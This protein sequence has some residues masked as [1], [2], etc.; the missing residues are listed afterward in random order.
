MAGPGILIGQ[1]KLRN[2]LEFVDE[3]NWIKNEEG[4]ARNLNVEK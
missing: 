2:I 3:V 1:R 4:C